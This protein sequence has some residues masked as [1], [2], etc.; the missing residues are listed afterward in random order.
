MNNV[1]MMSMWRNDMDHNIEKRM[2]HLLEK[3]GVSRWVWVVGNS[4]DQT[5]EYALHIA[6]RAFPLYNIK[7]VLH[8]SAHLGNDPDTRL[9]RLS[10]TANAGLNE[11]GEKDEWW[12]IH[13]SDLVSPIDL[14][15]RLYR[16]GASAGWVKLGNIFYDTWGYRIDGQKFI[17]DPPYHPA[18]WEAIQDGRT[19]VVDSAGS[20]LFFPAA[21][22]YWGL[23]LTNGGV[24]EL[25]SKLREQG[26]LIRVNPSI[27]IRQPENLWVGHGHPGY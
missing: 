16:S 26:H 18:A 11:V 13:E 5:W 10:E 7:V 20:V 19:F 17:N 14:V 12:C 4:D 21:P 2:E 27:I 8:D 1:V 9:L 25:C 6:N 24:V 22:L 3:E 23:R 15:P